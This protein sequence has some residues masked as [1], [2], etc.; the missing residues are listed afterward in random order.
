MLAVIALTGC[1]GK[2]RPVA[3]ADLTSKV[4]PIEFT[5]IY[6]RL[7]RTRTSLLKLLRQ[8]NPGRTVR[9]PAIDFGRREV[10]LVATGPRSSTGYVLR[11]VSVREAGNRLTVTIR[12]RTPTLG[13]PV[14]A[15]VTYPFRLLSVPRTAEHLRLKWLVRP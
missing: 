9:L 7:F 5:R 10:F 3:Y 1:A 11:V 8:M 4:G 6:V 2:T 13:E 12:E 14:T 15:R